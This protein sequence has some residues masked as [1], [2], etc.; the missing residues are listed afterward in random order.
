MPPV[1]Q[2]E[3]IQCHNGKEWDEIKIG[4]ALI[5][6]WEWEY[7]RCFWNPE[8]AET[9]KSGELTVEFKTDKTLNVIENGQIIQTSNWN[10][11]FRPNVYEISVEPV[12]TQL[13][14]NIYFCDN[15]VLFFESFRDLCDNYF[16][17][18]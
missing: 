5:G 10:I 15:R 9:I 11:T 7:V 6:E 2:S 12:V 4:D 17:R 16:K 8:N 3:M 18:K 14:G 1:E 13:S